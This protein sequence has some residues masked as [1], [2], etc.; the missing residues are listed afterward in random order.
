M[1][2]FDTPM[3]NKNTVEKRENAAN[4]YNIEGYK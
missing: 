3:K 4:S 1:A 2:T